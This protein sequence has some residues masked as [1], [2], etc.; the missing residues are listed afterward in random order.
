METQADVRSLPPNYAL[1]LQGAVFAPVFVKVGDEMLPSGPPQVLVYV[2]PVLLA[3]NANRVIWSLVLLAPE[4]YSI[5]LDS[6]ALVFHGVNEQPSLRVAGK[7]QVSVGFEGERATLRKEY[8]YDI[9][10][11]LTGP[12]LS[13]Q[14]VLWQAKI[15]ADPTVGVSTDPVEIPTYP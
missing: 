2:P 7:A 5:E 14:F 15:K 10:F 3:G 11:I 9:N 13:S 8:G 1:Y 12:G 6:P 4:A